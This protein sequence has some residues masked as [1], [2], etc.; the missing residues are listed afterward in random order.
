MGNLGLIQGDDHDENADT[1]TCNRPAAVKISEVLG[2]RLQGAAK[3]KDQRAQDDG[4]AATKAIGSDTCHSSAE[5][6][7]SREDGHDGTA[8]GEA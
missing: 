7:S 2:G 3:T 6:G 4:P 8:K 5:E 1:E